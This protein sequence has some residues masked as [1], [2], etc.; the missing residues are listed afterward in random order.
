MQRPAGNKSGIIERRKFLQ[1]YIE[2]AE[3]LDVVLTVEHLLPCL[4][5]IVKNIKIIY[6]FCSLNKMTE[7][8]IKNT[9]RSFS[10]I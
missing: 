3:L 9:S 2:I 10:Y 4:Y 6:P 1:R 7:Q 5:E 8:V